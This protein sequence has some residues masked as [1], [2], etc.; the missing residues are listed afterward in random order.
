ML[1]FCANHQVLSCRTGKEL[2]DF[3]VKEQVLDLLAV[4]G[5]LLVAT[6][7]SSGVYLLVVTYADGS[8]GL[9]VGKTSRTIGQR[10]V[11]HQRMFSEDDTTTTTKPLVYTGEVEMVYCLPILQFD[12]DLQ[13]AYEAVVGS[14][15]T[16]NQRQLSNSLGSLCE[17]ALIA[18]LRTCSGGSTYSRLRDQ[19]CEQKR[20]WLGLNTMTAVAGDYYRVQEFA[21]TEPSGAGVSA[22]PSEGFPGE[23][24]WATGKAGQFLVLSVY[25]SGHEL[26]V[27]LRDRITRE[28][29]DNGELDLESGTA[30][31]VK[32]TATTHA[33]VPLGAMP[34]VAALLA[35]YEVTLETSFNTSSSLT[36][37]LAGR[38]PSASHSALLSYLASRLGV[39]Q[40]TTHLHVN[41]YVL[42]CAYTRSSASR[43]A[44]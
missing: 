39:H 37:F 31:R 13:P 24:R 41:N 23:L 36:A 5:S 34:E 11:Q 3:C 28:L 14:A 25:L 32:M 18:L 9:Y 4:D 12:N 19:H 6:Y 29:T 43:V 8:V 21:P 33:I 10:F 16:M 22:V 17:M 44:R 1:S 15:P 40:P 27:P 2:V 35:A 26:D 7:R 20:K 30:A 42:F 38:T